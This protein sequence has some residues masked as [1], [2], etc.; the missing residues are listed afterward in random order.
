MIRFLKWHNKGITAIEAAFIIPTFLLM[1]LYIIELL[2]INNAKTVLLSITSDATKYFAKY[3]NTSKFDDF[4][5]KYKTK[6]AKNLEIDY[7]FEIHHDANTFRDYAGE[8]IHW[9]SNGDIIYVDKD[10]NGQCYTTSNKLNISSYNRANLKGRIF[11]VTFV[12]N[13]KFTNNLTKLCFANGS[14][15]KNGA[16]RANQYLLY[17]RGIG[18]C[19]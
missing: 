6:Y 17:A 1:V 2:F 5:N 13:Y 3:S 14:N 16:T 9:S 15:S 7:Y 11:I 8:E 4:I 10:N 18:I 12:A 19:E